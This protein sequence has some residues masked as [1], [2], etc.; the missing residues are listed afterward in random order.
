MNIRTIRHEFAF[1]SHLFVTLLAWVAPFLFSWQILIPAYA[2]VMLQFAIFGRCLLNREHALEEEDHATFYSYL[3]ERMGYSL[4]RKNVKWFV[5]RFLYPTM[6][7]V[8]LVW[9]WYLGNAPLLF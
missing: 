5:R 2:A 8:A 4:P 9:Q 1:W 3:L 6:S 7:V